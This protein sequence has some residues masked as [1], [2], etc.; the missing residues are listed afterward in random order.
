[1]GQP[2]ARRVDRCTGW[3]S[4]VGR[5]RRGGRS[6]R[7]GPPPGRRAL[8][9]AD[10]GETQRRNW[11][12]IGQQ[13]GAATAQ[14]LTEW[15][16]EEDPFQAAHRTWERADIL[17]AGTPELPFDPTSEVVVSAPTGRR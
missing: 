2:R 5:R 10:L 9:A 3:V 16:A 11:S 17:V 12:R 7:G 13:A 8:G 1:M 4:L 15:M 14:D 6:S